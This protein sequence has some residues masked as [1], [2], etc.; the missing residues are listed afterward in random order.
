MPLLAIPPPGLVLDGG[1][2]SQSQPA[3]I[4]GLTLNDSLMEDICKGIRSGQS[5]QLTLGSEPVRS[6]FY[7]LIL[8]FLHI[9]VHIICALVYHSVRLQH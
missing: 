4:I 3:A 8:H 9:N 6:L 5:L 2:A 1:D 7:C